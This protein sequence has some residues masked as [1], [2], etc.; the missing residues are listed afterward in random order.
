MEH[1]PLP[2]I[3]GDIADRIAHEIVSMYDLVEYDNSGNA[4]TLT[5]EE[6]TEVLWEIADSELQRVIT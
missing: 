6:A 4:R 3:R 2:F 5:R 1:K